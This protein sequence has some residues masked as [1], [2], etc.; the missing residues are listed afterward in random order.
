MAQG[1][2]LTRTRQILGAGVASLL[3]PPAPRVRDTLDRTLIAF[4]PRG[5]FEGVRPAIRQSI[6]G[7][8]EA[9]APGVPLPDGTPTLSALA[10]KVFERCDRFNVFRCE[11][12]D[13][14]LYAPEGFVGPLKAEIARHLYRCQDVLAERADATVL[15]EWGTS[16]ALP[17]RVHAV[18]ATGAFPVDAPAVAL[19]CAQFSRRIDEVPDLDPR[20]ID[21]E[22]PLGFAVGGAAIVFAVRESAEEAE[23]VFRSEVEKFSAESMPIR[24][25]GEAAA[26]MLVVDLA[27]GSA[28]NLAGDMAGWGMPRAPAP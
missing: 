13:L 24:G 21:D 23:E 26:E 25:P 12:G 14:M 2:V 7:F 15:L 16:D 11:A 9:F 6:G 17:T 3:R 20:R 27:E 1:S 8:P 18:R 10:R 28:R 5:C 22:G 19:T 4:G